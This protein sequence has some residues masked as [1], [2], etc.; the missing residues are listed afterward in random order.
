ML[1]NNGIGLIVTLIFCILSHPLA[2][3]VYV[4][5]VFTEILVLSVNT[6]LIL[7]EFEAPGSTI[8]KVVGRDQLKV[9]PAVELV[10]M[11]VKVVPL[12]IA[13]GDKVLPN[14]GVSLMMTTLT[15]VKGEP[16]QS[17]TVFVILYT[18]AG[19]ADRSMTP[20][21]TFTKTNNP[22]GVA[23]NNPALAPTE[24]DGEAFGIVPVQYGPV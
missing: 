10:A 21:L 2:D 8:P 4:Y 24:K 6:S 19:V 9:V 7:F 16:L 20:V 23:V 13:G 3:N 11:Y 1:L 14:T 22:T 5:R 17:L 15:S 18:P 12:H